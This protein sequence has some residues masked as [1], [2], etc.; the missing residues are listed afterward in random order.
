MACN[1][2][3]TGIYWTYAYYK[4]SD[5]DNTWYYPY[6]YPPTLR[7]ISNYAIGNTQPIMQKNLQELSTNL[8]LMIVLPVESK[9]LLESKYQQMME[10]SKYGI[11]HL[12]PKEYKI[13]TYLKTHLWES[14][15]ILPIINIEFLRNHIN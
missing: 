8:Q 4:K 13:H 6:A 15:P 7:D 11:S 10:D 3:I 12:Y 1:S 5:Y 14:A 2:Y 9:H